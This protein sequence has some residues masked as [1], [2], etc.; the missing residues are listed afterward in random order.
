MWDWDV[1]SYY[2][3][4]TEFFPKGTVPFIYLVTFLQSLMTAAGYD[5]VMGPGSSCNAANA[6]G[7]CVVPWGGGTRTVSS[8]ILIG[9]GISF[10][11]SFSVI[12][13]GVSVI[14]CQFI[15]WLLDNDPHIHHD[16]R[17]SRLWHNWPVAASPLYLYRLGIPVCLYE[18]D[19]C[20]CCPSPLLHLSNFM[21]P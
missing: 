19:Q 7:S 15:S 2:W 3:C 11:V 17:N 10:A 20:V 6:S 9:N 5:P 8:V 14:E 16:E 18:P 1:C 13:L 4:L 12:L 21:F